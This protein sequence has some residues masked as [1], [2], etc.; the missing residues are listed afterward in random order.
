MNKYYLRL[1]FQG[2]ALL[3]ELLA[4]LFSCYHLES[5]GDSYQTS[6]LS[7]SILGFIERL[8]HLQ[9]FRSMFFS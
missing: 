6:N 3:L 7:R 9:R 5:Q 1:Y 2:S 8:N 4:I